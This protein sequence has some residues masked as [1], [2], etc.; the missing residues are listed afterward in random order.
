MSAATALGLVLAALTM[1]SGCQGCSDGFTID[2][3]LSISASPETV[4][5]GSACVGGEVTQEVTITHNGSTGTL[6][7]G[8]ITLETDSDEITMSQPSRTEL[9]PGESTTVVVTY[10]PADEDADSAT[11][12]IETNVATVG[13]GLTYEIHIQ[14]I[15]QSGSLI[16]LPSPVD[17]GEVAGG[18]ATTK[19]VEV[20]NAGGAPVTITGADIEGGQPGDFGLPAI[21]E[22]PLV[23]GCGEKATLTVSYSPTEGGLDSSW[24]KIGYDTG[25]GDHLLQVQLKGGEIVALLSAF[26][27][28]VDFGWREVDPDPPHSIP[29]I[30]ANDGNLDLEISTFELALWSDESVALVDAPT[31]EELPLII[32]PGEQVVVM[33]TFAPTFETPYTTAPIAA[34]VLESNAMNDAATPDAALTWEGTSIVN[35][36]GRAEAPSLQVTPGEAVDFALVAT[37]LTTKRSVTLFNAGSA[38]LMVDAITLEDDVFAEYAIVSDETWG[39]LKSTPVPGILEPGVHKS[40][41]LEYTNTGAEAPAAVA[42][43]LLRILSNDGTTPDWPLNL[44]AT[45][46]SAPTCELELKPGNTDFGIV[47][48]GFTKTMTV[49]L[50]NAG[51]GNCSFD[52]ALVNDCDGFVFGAACPDPANT[53]KQAGD[54]EVYSVVSAP[55]AFKEGLKPGQT[56][57]IKIMFT[58]PDD[59][60]LFGDEFKDYAGFIGVRAFNPYV[61]DDQD[62]QADLQFFPQPAGGGSATS[63]PANLHG[64][65]GVADLSVFPG[66][67]DFG[68]TTIGC[69]SQTFE[70]NAC[71]VGTAPLD[72]TKFQQAGCSI[73]FKL[74]SWP[75]LP[76]TLDPQECVQFEM[77]YAP[78]D[79]GPDACGLELFTNA[80]DTAAVVVPISGEGTF[81]TEQTDVFIQ[82]SGQ[83]VDVLF[84]VDDSGSMGEEQSNLGNNF[85]KFI[86]EASAWNNDYHVGVTTTDID[87]AAGQLVGSPRYV[88]QTNWESFKTNVKVGTGGSGTERGLAA[89]QMALTLPNISDTATS[90]TANADC[91]E[92]DACYDG[93]CG[94]PNRGFM[95]DDAS[96][97]IVFVSDEEDQS[98]ADLSFY[99]NFLKSIKGFYNDNLLHVHAIVGPPGGCSSSS[100]DA[101]AGMRYIDVA[102][103]TGGNVASICDSDFASALESIG[104]IA[105]GLKVQFFLTRPA[106]PPTIEIKIDGV[107]C[108]DQSGGTIHWEYMADSNSVLFN[109]FGG[110]MPQPGQEIWI[111][112]ETI[113]FLE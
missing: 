13:G 92:P 78:Q 93:F 75:V 98:P 74:K 76:E 84:V 66:E 2:D 6:I 88:T 50:Y 40:V 43:A 111:H 113:C 32:P 105:F 59:A 109:E 18:E 9:E 63:F 10:S 104:E 26:P 51:S 96:L 46:A 44:K 94:G 47:P 22:L 52:S 77:V 65:S 34:V 101:V 36:Y 87:E 72:L 8:S 89:A 25:A 49:N 20:V 83:D 17:F 71:N 4:V 7:L 91:A 81:D 107:P 5:F 58:P 53:V 3:D 29:L 79:L 103:Q 38:D 21:P 31:A 48:R 61:D 80:S 57:E 100:G 60:P 70:V 55:P 54:S 110:C 86:T 106:D 108:E 85:S 14:G 39:P 42:W 19:Q 30:L 11:V 56:Y 64:K 24:L 45:R 28:P 15:T 62:G 69:Y 12:V 37:N 27:V 1:G 102:N 41:Q 33:V 97:E 95:R 35:V 82:T 73:E 16:A 90:C 67:L 99:I 112:Y 23:L 68:V